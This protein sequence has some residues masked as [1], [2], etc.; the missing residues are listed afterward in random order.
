MQGKG[1]LEKLF[2][3]FFTITKSN[4]LFGCGVGLTSIAGGSLAA[5]PVA[6][7]IHQAFQFSSPGIE[8]W[9]R[10]SVIVA[11]L[12]LVSAVAAIKGWKRVATFIGA[13]AGMILLYPALGLLSGLGKDQ[14]LLGMLLIVNGSF[15]LLFSISALLSVI[16]LSHLE[17]VMKR[18][19][20]C[21]DKAKL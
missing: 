8:H 7:D 4:A 9:L 18:R 16:L 13:F 20:K 5:H 2:G 1:L 15:T 12:C 17:A 3:K 6:F 14:D 19:D 10:A 21:T 11:S